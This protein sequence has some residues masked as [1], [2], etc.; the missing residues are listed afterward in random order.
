MRH[1]KSNKKL[2]MSTSPR[3]ALLKG[4]V[5][6]L[7]L[8]K[9]IKTTI[10]RAKEAQKLAEKVITLSKTDSVVA[11]RNILK[12]IPHKDILNVLFKTLGEKYKDRNG[13]YTRIIPLN[14]RKGDGATISILELVD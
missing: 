13:G 3:L 7:I 12:I 10:T 2:G 1:L 8:H 5:R 9:K 11:R 4:L 14:T 6:S